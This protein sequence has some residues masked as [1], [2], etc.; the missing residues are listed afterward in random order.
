[1]RC[2]ASRLTAAALLAV[3]ACTPAPSDTLDGGLLPI[4]ESPTVKRHTP[5]WAFE[6][7][8][9]QDISTGQETR[10]FVAGFEARDIPVG[11]VVIDSPWETNYHSFIP[12]E[13][14]YPDFKALVSELRTRDI[15]TVMWMTQHQNVESFD[16]E[17]G[18]DLY[19]KAAP[20]YAAGARAGH[21]VNDGGLDL[22]WK[23]RGASVDFFNPDAVRWWHRLQDRAFALGISGWKL[24]FGDEYVVGD[25]V[26]TRAGEVTKQAY[27]EAYYRDML[28]YGTW[29]L[30][31]EEFTTMSR[32]YDASYGFP[33]RFF[34]RREDCPIGWVGDNR[35]DWVGLVDALDHVFRSAQAGYVVLGSDIGG[36]LDLDDLDLAGPAIPFKQSVFARWTA[37]GALMPFMQLHGRGN[38][39]PW[40]VPELP[41]E[42]VALYRYW[43]TLHSELVPFFYSLSE[44]AYAGAAPP[45][46]RPVGATPA[47]WASDWRYLLGEAFLVAPVFD[48]TGSR[49]VA[50]PAGARWYDWWD[51][52]GTGLDGGTTLAAVDTTDRSRVPLYVRE[53]ALVPL[54]V[55]DARTGTGSPAHAGALTLLAWPGAAPSRFVLHGIAGK[56]ELAA[57]PGELRLSSLPSGAWVKLRLDAVPAGGFRVNGQALTPRADKAALEQAAEGTA[58]GEGHFT[59]LRLP[60][61]TGEAVVTW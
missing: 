55:K 58:P 53:G 26:R 11:V 13:A 49:D 33:G 39:A 40:T 6:P 25:T 44:E 24:D 36:Y 51:E 30:G 35:R 20:D 60:A 10:D 28:A 17:R 4:D 23:G 48:D 5:R 34:A 21:Y 61:S 2:P 47:E 57:K 16:A 31:P 52:G 19:G 12:N 37:L 32:P 22:W 41:D 3:S 29:A 54:S 7:W 59:W 8:I 56:V 15:R 9:S 46:I 38:F 1:M 18:G 50:L 43:A 42:T 14:R 45:P 27:S